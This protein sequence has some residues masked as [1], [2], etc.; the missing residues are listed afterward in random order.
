MKNKITTIILCIVLFAVPVLIIPNNEMYYN[1]A[2]YI[3]L[4]ICGTVLLGIFIKNSKKLVFD[5]TDICIFVFIILAL[6]STIF[7]INVKKSII[8]EKNRFE[9]L[10][11]LITYSM[12]Y[13]H[14]KYYFKPNKKILNIGLIV[15]S[16]IL[17]FAVI[18][19]YI[20]IKVIYILPIFGKGA[21]GTI[22]NTNFMGSFVSMI[23]PASVLAYLFTG[24]KKYLFVSIL[25][26]LVMLLCVA[27]SSWVAFAVTF[28]LIIAYMI[29]NRS[30]ENFKRFAFII[31]GFIMCLTI[32]IVEPKGKEIVVRKGKTVVSETKNATETGISERM[33]SGRILIWKLTYKVIKKYPIVGCGVDSL[34]DGLKK[35]DLAG[36]VK[37]INIYHTSIDK[38]HNE[39]LQIAATI[40]LPALGVYLIFIT[41]IL[42]K[43]LKGLL[44][45]KKST[46]FFI[47]I[48]GYLTQAFFN[49]STLGV[50][51]IYWIVL[52]LSQQKN[53]L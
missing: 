14:A 50:A 6:I 1:L 16:L 17:V 15:Y 18:Q 53:K 39:Y 7:S 38:A 34:A 43:N 20:P 19:F 4:L 5:K 8:G 37:Y 41:L 46:L 32:V 23:V 9:G 47:V 30:K 26:F 31:V 40:G 35:T 36:L 48:V 3:L 24:E 28:I 29:K 45:D 22:G 11:I 10:L 42:D 2:R 13:Y 52:G 49:I 12:L 25:S 44:K 51:P 27:R 21:H 33:G